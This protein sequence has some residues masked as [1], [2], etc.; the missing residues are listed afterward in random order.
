MDTISRAKHEA[1]KADVAE[2]KLRLKSLELAVHAAERGKTESVVPLAN[3][4][5]NFLLGIDGSGKSA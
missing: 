5:L 4:F 3:A 1:E 2:R